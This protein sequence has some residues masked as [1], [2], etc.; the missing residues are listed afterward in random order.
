MIYTVYAEHDDMTF[1]MQEDGNSQSVI[2][3]YWGEPD[4]ESTRI[5]AGHLTAYYEEVGDD[6]CTS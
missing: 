5:Y 2:G 6:G 1:I 3:W 4:A